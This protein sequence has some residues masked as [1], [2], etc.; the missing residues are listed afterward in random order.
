MYRELNPLAD[1]MSKDGL[2]LTVG[3]FTLEK[4]NDGLVSE[5]RKNFLL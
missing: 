1:A 2:L 4:I 5:I 3:Q